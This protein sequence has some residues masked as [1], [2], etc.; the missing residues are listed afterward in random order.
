MASLKH[1]HYQYGVRTDKDE[2]FYVDSLDQWDDGDRVGISIKPEDII[3]E[4][5]PEDIQ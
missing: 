2:F 1:N 5:I 4:F 3:L